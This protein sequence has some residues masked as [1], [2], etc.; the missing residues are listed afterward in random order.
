MDDLLV[1]EQTPGLLKNRSIALPEAD[2]AED[3]RFPYRF[4][5]PPCHLHLQC[6]RFFAEKVNPLGRRRHL[7]IGSGVGRH[8]RPHR[9]HR[10]PIEHFVPIGVDAENIEAIRRFAS[11]LFVQ[12]ANRHDLDPVDL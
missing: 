2:S 8:D 3:P 10:L 7:D 4:V 9:I 1:F 5:D 12:I 11:R 6:L